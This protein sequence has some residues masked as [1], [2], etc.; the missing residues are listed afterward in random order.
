MIVVILYTNISVSEDTMNQLKITSTL[1][2]NLQILVETSKVAI[3]HIDKELKSM[4]EDSVKSVCENMNESAKMAKAAIE[5]FI[6]RATHDEYG[7]LIK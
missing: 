4:P 2:K 5:D 7:E 6:Y 3:S 1:I